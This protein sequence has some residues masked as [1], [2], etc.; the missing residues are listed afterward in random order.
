ML[1]LSLAKG[2]WESGT[3][4]KCEYERLGIDR[5]RGESQAFYLS[6]KHP[7]L[8]CLT[9]HLDDLR[10]PPF[11]HWR[12]TTMNNLIPRSCCSSG[13]AW[14]W[15]VCTTFPLLSGR[16]PTSNEN[17][18]HRPIATNTTASMHTKRITK[19]WR[20]VA[21]FRYSSR[22]VTPCVYVHHDWLGF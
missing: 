4:G 18:Y 2:K 20:T 12:S 14:R 1:C 9:A 17:L 11:L 3:H 8:C 15:T 13:E 16:N 5:R 22:N 7:T 6:S 21:F 19:F 10:H